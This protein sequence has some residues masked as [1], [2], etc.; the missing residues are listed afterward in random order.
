MLHVFSFPAPAAPLAFWRRVQPRPKHGFVLGS[1]A[2][3][4]DDRFVYLSL[5]EPTALHKAAPRAV[6]RL[7][8]RLFRHTAPTIHIKRH[9]PQRNGRNRDVLRNLP[10]AVFQRSGGRKR[11]YRRQ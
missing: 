4:L 7:L 6:P 11:P 5:S 1:G 10:D 2:G 8:T 3:T 9:L